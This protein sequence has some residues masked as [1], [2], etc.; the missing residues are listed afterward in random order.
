MP[1]DCLMIWPHRIKRDRFEIDH[2]VNSGARTPPAA[3]AEQVISQ[4]LR[5]QAP[6]VMCTGQLNE[7]TSRT[8]GRL[9][10]GQPRTQR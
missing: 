5:A 9:R 8:L 7:P 2:S 6:R 10:A 1:C 3:V 4:G